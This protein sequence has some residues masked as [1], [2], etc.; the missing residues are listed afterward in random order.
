MDAP[1][2]SDRD[3]GYLKVLRLAVPIVL[4]NLTQPLL[5]M[6]DTAIAGHFA[7]V[8]ELGGVALGGLIFSF[9]FW[10]FGFLRM[11]T[12]GL[13]AQA[14][15]ADDD[16]A[17]RQ[18]LWRAGLLAVVIGAAILLFNVPLLNFTTTLLTDRPELI[19][20]ASLYCHARIWSAPLALANY[21]IL[22]FLLGVQKVHSALMLQIIVNLFNIMA[23]LILVYGA[24]LGVAGLG[25]ATAS[26]DLIG[27]VTGVFVISRLPGSLLHRPKWRSLVEPEQLKRLVLLNMNLFG[28]TLCLLAVFA[29]FT[30][31]SATLSVAVLAGNTVLLN[32]QTFMAYGL[33]GFAHACE[34]LVGAAI[35]AR[36]RV[37]LVASIRSST[38]LAAI[39]ASAFAA[40]YGLFGTSIIN[41]LT[42]LPAVRL[43]ASTYLPYAAFSPLISVWGFQLDGV[44]IGATRTRDLVLAM[45]GS[46]IVFAVALSLLSSF[47]NQ[48]LWLALLGFMAARG[49]SL[50]LFLPR[51]V[52][53]ADAQTA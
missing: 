9:I 12:T 3:V 5:S 20:Q 36:D 27:F 50:A 30:R 21:V 2:S 37:R 43:E 53:Q 26:A 4:A 6:V 34:A 13:V 33:D 1:K 32:L 23:A 7:D 44:F 19:R 14:F 8:A 45:I 22:G 52:R 29:W 16:M 25:A 47:G 35:G 18:V 42:S 31:A 48:G 51:L 39:V 11:S 10:G 24:H 28:R 38:V 40:V 49:V 17:L 41:A 15:G 46:C